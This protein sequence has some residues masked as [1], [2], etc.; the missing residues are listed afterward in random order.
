MS[1]ATK[2]TVRLSD[3]DIAFLLM[4]LRNSNRPLTTAQLVDALREQS[5]LVARD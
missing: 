4:I 2:E 1:D 5:L 3:D